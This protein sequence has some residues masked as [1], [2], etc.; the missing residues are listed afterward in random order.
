MKC[1]SVALL[2]AFGA[3]AFATQAW[4]PGKEYVYE[5]KTRTMTGIPSLKTQVSGLGLRSKVIV[6][7]KSPNELIVKMSNIGIARV[8][9]EVFSDSWSTW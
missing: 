7:V 9:N 4:I 8:V 3:V 1:L 5:Y 6:Q 2:F